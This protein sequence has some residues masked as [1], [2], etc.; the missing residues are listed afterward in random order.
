LH[1]FD[2]T[3]G[4]RGIYSILCRFGVGN[5]VD[6]PLCTGSG[7]EAIC[8]LSGRDEAL[9]PWVRQEET[10]LERNALIRFI[11]KGV[12]LRTAMAEPEVLHG[13]AVSRKRTLGLQQWEPKEATFEV[14][15]RLCAF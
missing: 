12:S 14:I 7:E 2:I 1:W 4:L 9:R 15:K 10:I 11:G 5:P 3:Y 6:V 13:V 8:H